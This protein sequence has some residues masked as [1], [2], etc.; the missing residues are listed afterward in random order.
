[1][2]DENEYK[3]DIT[4]KVIA[5]SLNKEFIEIPTIDNHYI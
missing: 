4:Y 5:Q 3:I 2:I 1:M